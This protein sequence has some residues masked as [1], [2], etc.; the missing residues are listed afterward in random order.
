MVFFFCTAAIIS[1]ITICYCS[2][3][4]PGNQQVCRTDA[5][6]VLQFKYNS[7][8]FSAMQVHAQTNALK[9][10]CHVQSAG[11]RHVSRMCITNDARQATTTWMDQADQHTAQRTGGQSQQQKQ[12]SQQHQSNLH[13]T[14]VR[15]RQLSSAARRARVTHVHRQEVLPVRAHT[16]AQCHGV[17]PR[18]T[19]CSSRIAN[20]LMTFT[21]CTLW[22]VPDMFVQ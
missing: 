21:F 10:F 3:N 18:G 6:I 7:H 12:R 5:M 16:S 8:S 20:V 2:P 9:F 17:A 11:D 14:N 22:C 19:L 1:L 15:H 13:L 4:L